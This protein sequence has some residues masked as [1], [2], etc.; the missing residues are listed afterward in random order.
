[1]FKVIQEQWAVVEENVRVLKMFFV[2]TKAL[3]KVDFTLSD[4]YGY[5][6]VVRE[7]LKDY[8]NNV[9]QVSNLAACIATELT[10]RLPM[11]TKNP[12]MLCAVFFDRRYSSELSGEEKALAIETVIKIWEQIR[13]EVNND[14][15][16]SENNIGTGG[17]SNEN[18]QFEFRDSA[19]V[20]ENY[21]C[22]KGVELI[23]ADVLQNKEPNFS[24]SNADMYQI[25]A[26]FDEKIGRQPTNKGVLEF[27]EEQK[28]I[29]PEIYLLSTVINAI[30][31]TQAST[32]R[33]FSS[34]NFIFDEKR[35]RL[36]LTLLEQILIIKLN[37]EMVSDIFSEQLTAIEKKKP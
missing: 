3:Q 31:P 34:L 10:A 5:L 37:K 23:P 21:F 7:N 26:Q 24:T 20:L 9:P 16:N 14:V 15:N 28:Y 30:P 32:E 13:S 1:M 11:I 25:L 33:C 12:M 29:F 17:T 27:W 22:S 2:T 8:L 35:T 36:S 19:T 6:I 4:F 18:Q